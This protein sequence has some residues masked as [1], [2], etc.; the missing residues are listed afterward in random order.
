MFLRKKNKGHQKKEKERQK[1]NI[2]C[3]GTL[4]FFIILRV[5]TISLTVSSFLETLDV[6][7]LKKTS[8]TVSD[9]SLVL[10]EI[11]L[12]KRCPI[13]IRTFLAIHSQEAQN[14]ICPSNYLSCSRSSPKHRGFVLKSA[15]FRL[16]SPDLASLCQHITHISV[17]GITDKCVSSPL[18]SLV[19][20]APIATQL[21]M[22]RELHLNFTGNSRVKTWPLLDSLRNCRSLRTLRY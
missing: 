21:P 18:A 22:L 19:D 20:L 14:T 17:L 4:T 15:W 5:P 12:W 16:D 6:L 3:V 8:A 10:L 1:R 9:V 11:S 13:N 7:S 2:L